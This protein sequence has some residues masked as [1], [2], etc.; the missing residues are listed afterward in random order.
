MQPYCPWGDAVAD[1]PTPSLDYDV[2]RPKRDAC[3]SLRESSRGGSCSFGPSADNGPSV[4][5]GTGPSGA[6]KV[7]GP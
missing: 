2:P 4:P 6:C 1:Q 5:E 7:P 3:S